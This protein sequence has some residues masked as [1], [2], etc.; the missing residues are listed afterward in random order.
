MT[1]TNFVHVPYKGGAPATAD[2]L[3]GQVQLLIGGIATNLP[4]LKSGK[5]RALGVTSLRR[6]PS[7]P[8]VPAIAETVQGYDASV[9]IG[10]VAPAGTPRPAIERVHRAVAGVLQDP[11]LRARLIAQGY[12]LVANT[13]EEF[14]ALIRSDTA[15]WAKVI[16]D[17]NIRAE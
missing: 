15:K 17:A 11:E 9:W 12:D 14:A 10:L 4:H 1:G 16:K 2:L 3:G 13:P 7:L 8:E 5:L 6:S